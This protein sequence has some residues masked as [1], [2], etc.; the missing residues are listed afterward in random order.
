MSDIASELQAKNLIDSPI[1]FKLYLKINGLEKNIQA[2][3]YD[4]NPNTNIVQMVSVFQHGINDVKITFVE[5]LRLEQYAAVVSDKF[6]DISYTDFMTQAK[7]LEGY[8]FPDT[9]YFKKTASA[10][11]IVD[12]LKNTFEEKTRD[13]LKESDNPKDTIILASIIERESPADPKERA[14]VAGILLKRV[15]LVAR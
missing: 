7:D 4:I 6:E 5:G 1:I 12:K 8:L 3:S 2:G 9:Y 11:D 15:S 13:M 14:I 10:Q